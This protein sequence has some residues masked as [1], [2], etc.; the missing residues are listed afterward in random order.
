MTVII[1]AELQSHPAII[2]ECSK[3]GSS[4][5]LKRQQALEMLSIGIPEG[6]VQA[7]LGVSRSTLWRWKGQGAT[8]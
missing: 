8:D 7:K 6:E 4:N 3:W 5:H 2:L 1:P